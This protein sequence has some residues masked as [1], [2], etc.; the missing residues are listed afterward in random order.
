MLNPLLLIV[1][2]DKQIR[3]F[4]NFSLTSQDYE[5]IEAT[6]GKEAINI[7]A[8]HN[9]SAIILDLG[10]PDMS[11]MDIIR[12]V[13]SFSD[14]PIIVVSAHDQDHD[15]VEALDAG[16]DDY[17]TKPFSIKELLAR[18]RVIFRHF[19]VT[20]KDIPSVYRVGDLEIDMEKHKVSLEGREIHFTPM[21]YAVL[22]L[23]VKNA[24]KVLTH[25]Y[26]LKEVWGSDLESDMQ[27]VRVFM[28]NIRRKLENNPTKPRYILTEVGIG[29]RF[30]DE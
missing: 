29:Y 3:N 14:I 17:L 30:A 4:I 15:K 5:C 7:I 23:L 25:K 6:T 26:I 13:R 11:G 27:S 20:K 22:T 21:E 1:E 24:G 16:A 9:L 18:I 8:T 19:D 10:L 2:D 12:K 28:A